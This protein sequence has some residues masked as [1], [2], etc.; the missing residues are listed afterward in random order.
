MIF[1]QELVSPNIHTYNY[2][3]SYFKDR[4]L[5]NPDWKSKNGSSV[6]K[7]ELFG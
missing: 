3:G 4:L 5:S 6:A 7:Q 2:T 1:M